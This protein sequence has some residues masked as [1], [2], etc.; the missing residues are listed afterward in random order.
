MPGVKE[1]KDE[2]EHEN[3]NKNEV[4][5]QHTDKPWTHLKMFKIK[6][7]NLFIAILI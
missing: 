2:D 4:I 7:C 5:G 6:F 3:D 1:D